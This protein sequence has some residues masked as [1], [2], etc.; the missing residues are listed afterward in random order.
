[1]MRFAYFF[2]LVGAAV[3]G[4][5]LDFS[6]HTN[7]PAGID[8]SGTWYPQPFQ[9]S[10]LITASGALVEFGGIPMNEAGR[11]YAL[12]WSAARIQGRQ[13]QCMGY[14]VP[15][16]YNQPGNLRFWEERDPHTQRLV[17][18]KHYWQISEG[19]RTIWMDDRPHPPAYA[20]HTWS[21]FSTGKYV[22]NNLTVYTTH[23]K[24]GWIRANGIPQSDEATVTEH[25]IKHGDRITYF[26]VVNDPVYLS[27]PFSRT[28]SLGR[29]EKEPDAWLY[30]CDDGEQI[31][32][33]HEDQVDSYFWGQHPFL[34]EFAN[35]EHIPLLAT[36]GGPETM[37]PEFPAKYND[38][39]AMEAEAKKE[40]TPAPGPEH[41]GRAVDPNP[42]D[43]EIHVLPVQGNVFM[44]VGDGGNIALQV[45]EEA[46]LVVNTG[47]GQLADKVIAAIRKLSDKPIQFI[48]NTQH[49]SDFTGGNLKLRA[50]GHD[51]SLE[52]SF[53]SGQFADAGRSATIIAHQNVQNHMLAVKAA[54]ESI[55]SD[56]FFQGRRRKF[57]NGEA[58][59]IFYEPNAITD[60]DTIVHFRRS[61]VIA[62]G[63]IFSTTSYPRIDLKN[64]GSIQG[65]IQALDN[66]LDRTVYQ[67]DE[68]G[69]TLII[70]GHGRLCD[71]WELAEYRDMLVI[72][73]DRIQNLIKS[74]ASLEQ[75]KAARLTA[76][77]DDRFGATS[78]AWTTDL[79]VEAVYT[80]LKNPP[81][82]GSGK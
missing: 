66:I 35:K 52:G 60:G 17:A 76:D 57:H 78:G 46:P 68:E 19:T 42:R 63:D 2:V 72:V 45:G 27:E 44:L 22:G 8:I 49:A 51:P 81:K 70:P 14:T 15:Y 55:P 54:N 59:E 18:I 4:Q 71:E 56:T 28:Y 13:H 26:A 7:L 25:F 23:L 36:L 9:D 32:G 65:E 74:G 10:G 80:S 24:R 43:G 16:T 39:Q 64:G 69:G 6:G 11:L 34:R 38:P 30:A 62:A 67:H 40:L 79:F 33:R 75:V 3:W 37:Y 41:A 73:R 20:Q 21:G 1:M 47:A 82:S 58:V 29:N 31:L 48:V 53:F 61:D 50:A 5:G 77:Y 12:A